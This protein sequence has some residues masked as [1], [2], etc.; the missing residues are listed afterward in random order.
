MLNGYRTY[1]LGTVTIIGSVA[2]YLVGDASMAD[3]INLMVIAGMG[4]FVRSGVT[5]VV[6]SAVKKISG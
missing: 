5:T 6:N 4:M 2:S 3:T 1:I